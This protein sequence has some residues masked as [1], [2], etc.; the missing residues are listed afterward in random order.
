MS[1]WDDFIGLFTGDTY[2][3]DNPERETRVNEL[4]Y[5]CSN[6]STQLAVLDSKIKTNFEKIN[7]SLQTVYSEAA[8]RPVDLSK[9]NIQY[10]QWG[11]D[12][13]QVVAPLVTGAAVGAALNV[14][15]TSALL[16]SGQIALHL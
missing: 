16:A 3:P 14:A 5:D 11:V 7:N 2:F 10:D 15:A 9:V 13:A 4:A 12:V 6:F 8:N 1:A